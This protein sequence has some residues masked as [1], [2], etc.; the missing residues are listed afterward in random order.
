MS[1]MCEYRKKRA[2][3]RH[4]LELDPAY[5]RVERVTCMA[6]LRFI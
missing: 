6:S 5:N 2:S 4:R 3:T 1:A